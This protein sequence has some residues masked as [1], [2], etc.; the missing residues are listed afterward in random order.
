MD[1]QSLHMKT[2]ADLRKLAKEMGVR[3]PAGTKKN[4]LIDLLLEA[5]A[6]R[7]K[8]A[9]KAEPVQAEAPADIPAQEAA[10]EAP[11]DAPAPKRRGRQAKAKAPKEEMP[12]VAK[13]PKE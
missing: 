1:Y 8:S 13:P 4:V 9:A 6:A 10:V 3:V 12:K 7:A 2:V 11:A 5:D